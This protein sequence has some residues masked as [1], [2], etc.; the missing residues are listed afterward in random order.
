MR[1]TVREPVDART[2]GH[3]SVA[4]SGEAVKNQRTKRP[5]QIV[6][7]DGSAE[8]MEPDISVPRWPQQPGERAPGRRT[9]PTARGIVALLQR[10]P[11]R[12]DARRAR[13]VRRSFG[14]D[15]RGLC[16]C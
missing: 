14:I 6:K 9:L 7:G 5:S 2:G 1:R 3:D 10:C 12:S 13:I 4:T 11:A 16:T 15:R 8:L